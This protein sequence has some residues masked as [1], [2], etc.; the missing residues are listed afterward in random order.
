MSPIVS[1]IIPS[2]NTG[3]LLPLSVN[4]VLKSTLSNFE[5]IIIDDGSSDNAEKVVK[6]NWESE[7]RVKYYYQHN[8]GLAGARNTGIQH[9]IGKYLVFLDSDDIVLPE[10]LEK[11]VSF[12]ENNKMFDAVYSKSIFFIE[13]ELDETIMT[14]F[15][16]Y[17]GNILKPLLYGNFIHVNAIMCRKEVVE[18]AGLFNQ[19]YRELEDWDLWLRMNINGSK[20]GYIDDVLSMVM[21]RRG[22]MTSNQL[23]MNKAMVKVLENLKPM[24]ELNPD[25]NSACK[26]DYHYALNL[27]RINA[28]VNTRFY[29]GLVKSFNDVGISFLWPTLKLFTKRMIATIVPLKNKTTASLEEV[30]NG[31]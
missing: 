31:K 13:N 26:Y 14:N 28:K 24:L 6:E 29:S 8:K 17:S 18:K 11:Q 16:C 9:A 25:I 12:L 10:K 20:F 23:K 30:W 1:V 7:S 5:V 22:S 3:N 27:Y 4:S 21:L 15:P 19:E 2:Y